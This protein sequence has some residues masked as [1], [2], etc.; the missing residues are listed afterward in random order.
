[1]PTTTGIARPTDKMQASKQVKTGGFLALILHAHMPFVRHPEQPQMLE[2][3]WLYEAI[4]EAYLPILDLFARLETEQVPFRLTMTITPT[5]ANMLE[6]DLLLARHREYLAKQQELLE[7]EAKRNAA[8]PAHLRIVEHY[9][10]RLAQANATLQKWGGK[11]INAL[12]HYQKAG[13]LELITCGATHGY[14]PLLALHPEAVRAQIQVGVLEHLRI[15]GQRPKGIWLPECAYCPEVEPVLRDLG[16]KYF[17]LD[18]HGIAYAKPRP[19]MGVYGPIACSSGVAAFARDVETGQQVWSS[20]L[21]YPGDP[22]YREY[23]KDIGHELELDYLAPFLPGGW[24]RA[25]TGI[26]YHRVTGRDAQKKELYEPDKAMAK[27][28][29]HANHFLYSREKQ[30][31]ELG[32][33]LTR[34]PIVVAPYDCELFGHWWYEGPEFLYALLKKT[35]LEGKATQ[36][37][38]PGDYLDKYQVFEKATPT[39]SSW[40]EGGYSSVWLNEKTAWI[41]PKMH[42]AAE[43]MIELATSFEEAEGLELRAL[44]QAARELLLLQAS[45]WA[46]II[47]NETSVEYATRR[48]KEHYQRFISLYEE[49]KHGRID[50]EK[51]AQVEACDSLFPKINYRVFKKE[52]V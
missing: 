11:P 8:S 25:N 1:M 21:G 12:R 7:L 16:I 48:I 43:K 10:A 14:L 31:E 29:E 18:T 46:F 34:R 33:I 13:Y 39:P 44:N 45:D 2:E 24:L 28:R 38:T 5:L 17:I 42:S 26:K 22:W 49:L 30:L 23:Y 20:H 47:K 15:F 52:N 19:S 37:C 36:L 3:R 51:L 35:A 41:Y 50:A 6:D 40:G 32:A 27:A 4:G 9:T